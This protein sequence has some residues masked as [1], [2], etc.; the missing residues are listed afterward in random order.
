MEINLQGN[1]EDWLGLGFFTAW[2]QMNER[3]SMVWF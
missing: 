2:K 1:M 3:G